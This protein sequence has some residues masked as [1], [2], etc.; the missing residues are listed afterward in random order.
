MHDPQQGH[1][2]ADDGTRTSEAILEPI[3]EKRT[4]YQSKQRQ[5]GQHVDYQIDQVI[6]PGLEFAA[7]VVERQGQIDNGPTTRKHPTDRRKVE[8][9]GVFLQVSSVI[10]Q[11]RTRKAVR[12]DGHPR[13]YQQD[14]KP[15]HEGRS[16]SKECRSLPV[17]GLFYRLFRHG[18]GQSMRR[19]ALASTETRT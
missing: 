16:R 11:E 9:A 1:C 13:E 19:E 4:P 17:F 3:R 10:E 12:I 6:T 2:K 7:C 5:A 18:I 8:N 14:R 15:D